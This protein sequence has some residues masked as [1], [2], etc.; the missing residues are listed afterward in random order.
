MGNVLSGN[1]FPIVC[2]NCGTTYIKE[3]I[4]RQHL[5]QAY[6]PCYNCQEYV[7]FKK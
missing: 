1:S 3:E 5:S 4:E 6:F 2:K 7:F